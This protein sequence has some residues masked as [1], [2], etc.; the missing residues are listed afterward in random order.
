MFLSFVSFSVFFG[1]EGVLSHW[2]NSLGAQLAWNPTKCNHMTEE[3]VVCKSK[4]HARIL[5]LSFF[6][7]S[8]FSFVSSLL[9]LLMRIEKV[10][11][12]LSYKIFF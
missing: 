7:S 2:R 5:L 1:I 8:F 11:E 4:I 10:S 9:L 6:L 12:N 3:G